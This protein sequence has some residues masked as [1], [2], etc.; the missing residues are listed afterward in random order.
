[1]SA[2]TI[3]IILVCLQYAL[4][5]R[6]LLTS[7]SLAWKLAYV[8]KGWAGLSLL[9]TVSICIYKVTLALTSV[10]YEFERRVI[11]QELIAFDKWFA[12]GFS[13]KSRVRL[14]AEGDS[15]RELPGPLE[16]V[17]SFS[18]AAF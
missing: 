9:K 13:A 12:E 10:Q 3:L 17:L 16:S 1:M 14:A 4:F 2:S 8:L 18:S 6:G 5:Q 11:A 15:H 7:T